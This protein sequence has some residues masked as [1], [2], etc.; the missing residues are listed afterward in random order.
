M[1]IIYKHLLNLQ[2]ALF[3]D[4]TACGVQ[5]LATDEGAEGTEAVATAQ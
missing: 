2:I 4:D 3:E 1:C 5:R